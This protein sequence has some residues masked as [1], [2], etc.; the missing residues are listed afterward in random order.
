MRISVLPVHLLIGTLFLILASCASSDGNI[1][2]DGQELA[3]PDTTEL[4]QV[5]DLRINNLDELEITVFGVKDLSGIYQVDSSG[6]VDLPLIG[7]IQAKGFTSFEIAEIIEARYEQNHLQS[8]DVTVKLKQINVNQVT[9]EGSVNK[10]GL[11]PIQGKTTL[12]QA[13]ALSG[14]L[15]DDANPKRVVIFRQINNQRH[16][17]GFSLKDIR[18]GNAKDPEIYGNDIIVVDGGNMRSTYLDAI[19]SIPLLA[20]FVAL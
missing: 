18:N 15:S 5:G 3:A 2:Y 7:P 19:R 20:L 17:A 11:Y 6:N 9:V 4:V 12:V 10:P 8:A 14:G 16:A 1:S 13:V